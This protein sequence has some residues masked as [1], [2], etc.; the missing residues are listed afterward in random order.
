MFLDH[1]DFED[2]L[3]CYQHLVEVKKSDEEKLRI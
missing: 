1:V 2:A 3:A